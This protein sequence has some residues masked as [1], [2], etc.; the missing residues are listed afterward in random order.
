MLSQLNKV[1]SVFFF[2]FFVQIH[3]EIQKLAS[4]HSDVA[5]TFSLGKSL[6]NRDQ[7]AIKVC[8]L[9]AYYDLRQR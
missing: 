4:A 1:F 8:F 2:F 9:V 5:S 6:Q 7:L 3:S